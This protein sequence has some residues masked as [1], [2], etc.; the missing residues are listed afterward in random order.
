LGFWA[1]QKIKIL[2]GDVTLNPAAFYFVFGATVIGGLDTLMEMA[3]S[4]NTDFI[5]N[6]VVMLKG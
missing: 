1:P 4:Y 3:F 5:L 6:T 2:N